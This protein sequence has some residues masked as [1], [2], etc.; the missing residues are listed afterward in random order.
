MSVQY[1]HIVNW[2]VNAGFLREILRSDGKMRR[3]PTLQGERLGITV[4]ERTVKNGPYQVVVYSEA[5]QRF[6]VDNL[7]AIETFSAQGKE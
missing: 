7:E 5:A 1:V 4:E 3:R 6:V 2:L